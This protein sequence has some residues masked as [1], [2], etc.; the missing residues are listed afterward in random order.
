MNTEQELSPEQKIKNEQFYK[1]I[2]DIY[3]LSQDYNTYRYKFTNT[4]KLNDETH[5][6]IAMALA[7]LA[8]ENGIIN[9]IYNLYTPEDGQRAEY[10]V[11]IIL[12]DIAINNFSHDSIIQKFQPGGSSNKYVPYPSKKPGFFSRLFGT[13]STPTPARLSN[14][15]TRKHSKVSA[16]LPPIRGG[17]I[18]FRGKRRHTKKRRSSSIKRKHRNI[19]SRVRK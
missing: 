7:K 2:G 19:S 17:S 4:R 15:I 10:A 13:K 5:Y 16:I 11:N 9:D 18:S 8:D 1:Y 12:T 14:S 6:K 3:T